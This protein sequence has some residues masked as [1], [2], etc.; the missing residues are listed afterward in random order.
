MAGSHFVVPRLFPHDY[1]YIFQNPDGR[2]VFAIP[3]EGNFTRP[4]RPERIEKGN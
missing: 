1:A 2:V 4:G 3:Y